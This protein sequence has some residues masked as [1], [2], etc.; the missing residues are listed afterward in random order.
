MKFGPVHTSNAVGAILAHS[1]KIGGKR[2][3]KG[4]VL[5]I[6]DIDCLIS[7]GVSE[8][9]VARLE[10]GDV[11]E[12]EAARRLAGAISDPYDCGLKITEA[13]TG[14]VNLMAADAGVVRVDTAKIEAFNLVNPMITIATVPDFYLADAGGMLATIKI[15]SF[16]V[17][18]DDLTAASAFIDGAISVSRPKLQTARLIVT[19]I[20][21]LKSNKGISAI[22]DRLSR[23]GMDLKEVIFCAHRTDELTFALNSIEEDLALILT[24]S[25]TSD[26][27]DIAPA[28]VVASGGEIDRFGMPVDPG[29][30]LFIGSLGKAKVIGLPGCARSPALNGTDWVLGRIACGIPVKDED[31]AAMGVGGL[32]KEIPTRPHPRNRRVK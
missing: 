21:G 7:G 24:A 1:V 9:V 22:H 13:F 15:I 26:I 3:R 10:D 25:A 28:S 19:E 23:W 2:I 17:R 31:I 14:R 11:P 8:V 29:N 4:A 27:N 5:S 32:L 6:G 18:E 20:D 12:N 30:L 16:A